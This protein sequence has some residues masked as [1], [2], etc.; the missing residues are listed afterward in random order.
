MP[1]ETARDEPRR[2]TAM[3]S[4]RFGDFVFDADVFALRRAGAV[5]PLQPQGL[6]VL[7]YLIE[8]RGRMVA[9]TE[10]LDQLWRGAQPVASEIYNRQLSIRWRSV[11][12][13]AGVFAQRALSVEHRRASLW[14][15][16]M[17]G[18]VSTRAPPQSWATPLRFLCASLIAL[19]VGVGESRSACDVRPACTRMRDG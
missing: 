4:Y 15:P 10:L 7:R 13:F 19:R 5:L 3:G 6:D 8:N 16:R 11:T 9:K 17:E 2:T 14:K 1:H 12:P 18:G